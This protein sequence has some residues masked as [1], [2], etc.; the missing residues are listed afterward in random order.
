VINPKFTAYAVF[1]EEDIDTLMLRAEIYSVDQV[2]KSRQ[3]VYMGDG[4]MSLKSVVKNAMKLRYYAEEKAA[5]D[6]AAQAAAEQE[7]DNLSL[8]SGEEGSVKSAKSGSVKSAKSGSVKSGRSGSVK[9]ELSKSQ[10]SIKSSASAKNVPPAAAPA[11]A[12]PAPV[13]AAAPAAAPAPAAAAVAAAPEADDDEIQQGAPLTNMGE[14]EAGDTDYQSVAS[15]WLPWDIKSESSGPLGP[16]VLTVSDSDL[17]SAPPSLPPSGRPSFA[18]TPRGVSEQ[19]TPRDS[20]SSTPSTKA[21]IGGK[22]GPSL[23]LVA[24]DVIPIQQN[25]VKFNLHVRGKNLQNYAFHYVLSRTHMYNPS[26]KLPIHASET[27]GGKGRF[28]E[29]ELPTEVLVDGYSTKLL[30]TIYNQ[31]NQM[32][33]RLKAPLSVLLDIDV[34]DRRPYWHEY[35]D[36]KMDDGEIVVTNNVLEEDVMNLSFA[37]NYRAGVE[38]KLT[39]KLT[40]S[41]TRNKSSEKEPVMEEN[42]MADEFMTGYATPLFNARSNSVVDSQYVR[43][44]SYKTAPPEGYSEIDDESA[45]DSRRTSQASEGRVLHD[46]ASDNKSESGRSVRSEASDGFFRTNDDNYSH[47]SSRSGASARNGAPTYGES[48]P[49]SKSG[50]GFKIAMMDQFFRAKSKEYRD[51]TIPRNFSQ[52]SASAEGAEEGVQMYSGSHSDIASEGRSASGSSG[53]VPA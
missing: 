34:R 6:L 38:N 13:P 53:R 35:L 33:G 52:L 40:R 4:V 50:K 19:A 45:A 36:V 21:A 42:P 8:K 9:S 47:M 31:H 32:I 39:K 22:V 10:S 26:L 14:S 20:V 48:M 16:V 24:Q 44:L 3:K 17:E 18:E 29:V 30:L 12:P 51:L 41:F 1:D 15:N 23:H 46:E 27:I 43:S 49:R 5:A 7:L 2:F 25:R 11:P 37:V 28:K